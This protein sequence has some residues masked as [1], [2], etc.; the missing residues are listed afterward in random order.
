MQPKNKINERTC[1]VNELFVPAE[2]LEVPARPRPIFFCAHVIYPPQI[3]FSFVLPQAQHRSL[4]KEHGMR[5]NRS[6]TSTHWTYHSQKERKRKVARH[7]STTHMGPVHRQL[8]CRERGGGGEGG[9][10]RG[11]RSGGAGRKL[12][13]ITVFGWR[14][15]KEVVCQVKSLFW[16]GAC[17]VPFR[18]GGGGGATQP[19]RQQHSDP[20]TLREQGRRS[21]C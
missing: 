10:R 18:W 12:S 3:R 8:R 17:G 4:F 11:R 5:K 21:G 15:R 9:G 16:G 6:L 2:S 7:C 14:L 13:G 20:H 19:N 1:R